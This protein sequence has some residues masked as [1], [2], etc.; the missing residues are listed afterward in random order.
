[1]LLGHVQDPGRACLFAVKSLPWTGARSFQKETTHSYRMKYGMDKLCAKFGA[2]GWC[3]EVSRDPNASSLGVWHLNG[4]TS[5]LFVVPTCSVSET[6]TRPWV[7][8]SGYSNHLEIACECFDY[9]LTV[10][11]PAVKHRLKKVQKYASLELPTTTF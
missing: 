1:M 6:A 5:G 9:S 10:F 8:K 3:K 4:G 11:E 2:Q 7:A